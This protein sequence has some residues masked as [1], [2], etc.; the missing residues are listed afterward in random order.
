[1]I[2]KGNV[3]AARAIKA[4][5]ESNRYFAKQMRTCFVYGFDARVVLYE[6]EKTKISLSRGGIRLDGTVSL[7]SSV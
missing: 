3:Q 5:K 7:N 1:M 6:G 2:G 4:G